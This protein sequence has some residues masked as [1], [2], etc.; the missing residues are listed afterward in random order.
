MADLV[1][2]RA[3]RT[4]Q[5][6]DEPFIYGTSAEQ[7][8]LANELKECLLEVDESKMSQAK[9]TVVQVPKRP[10]SRN[11]LQLLLGARDLL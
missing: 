2:A 3:A 11:C 10:Y 5:Y 4:N 6:F 7:A 9:Q 8:V 1:S